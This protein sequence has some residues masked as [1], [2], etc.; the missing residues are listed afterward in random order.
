MEGINKNNYFL[1]NI[2]SMNKEYN[3]DMSASK[4]EAQ[5]KCSH[6]WVMTYLD[7]DCTSAISTCPKCK[8]VSDIKECLNSIHML[9][10]EDKRTI[11]ITLNSIYNSVNI[12]EEMLNI[13]FKG[14][15]RE[16]K[17]KINNDFIASLSEIKNINMESND[18]LPRGITRRSDNSSLSILNI[19]PLSWIVPSYKNGV[20]LV[21]LEK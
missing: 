9:N 19:S 10:S 16:F 7:E 17:R 15:I 5:E 14:F 2:T 13:V 4:K 8:E 11:L 6:F 18:D 1:N 12:N 20:I 21:P 3:I